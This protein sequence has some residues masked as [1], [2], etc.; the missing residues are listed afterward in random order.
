MALRPRSVEFLEGLAAALNGLPAEHQA[1]LREWATA[2]D[3]AELRAEEATRTAN[4][5]A[6]EVVR[7]NDLVTTQRDC[8]RSVARALAAWETQL[9]DS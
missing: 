4:E 9:A 1:A 5:L 8:L 7:L 3:A 6:A 2:A